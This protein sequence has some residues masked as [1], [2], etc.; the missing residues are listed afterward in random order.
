MEILIQIGLF[1]LLFTA[2]WWFGRQAEQRHWAQLLQDEARLANI[3]ISS[4]RFIHPEANGQ[5]VCAS[6]V[7]AQDYFK[8]VW[9][10][11]HNLL[12]GNLTTYETLLDRARR[13]AIVRLKAKAAAQGASQILG[14]RLEMSDI[15]AEQ[16]MVEVLAYGTMIFAPAQP[17]VWPP[18]PLDAI[19]ATT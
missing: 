17:S 2:G 5:L 7:I 4:E 12:G 13:E 18:Q 6:V 19:G 1:L 14:V 15:S 11:I 3:R 10:N 8:L 16:G 9:A